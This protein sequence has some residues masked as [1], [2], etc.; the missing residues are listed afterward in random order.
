MYWSMDSRGYVGQQIDRLKRNAVIKDWRKDKRRREEIVRLLDGKQ[1]LGD[2]QG[3]LNTL[4]VAIKGYQ[5]AVKSGL[6]E[7][8]EMA[9]KT[10][11]K[12]RERQIRLKAKEIQ[13]YTEFWLIDEHR[14][15]QITQ[16]W[17]ETS[18]QRTKQREEAQK[19]GGNPLSF[20]SNNQG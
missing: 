14:W 2:V 13:I 11:R 20:W 12:L 19:R 17:L 4:Q 9:L 10:M 5:K 8:P 15:K 16:R 18:Y 3:E 1:A 6:V 7:D